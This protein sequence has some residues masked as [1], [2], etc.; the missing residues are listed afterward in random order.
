MSERQ[1]SLH[2]KEKE[3]KPS[4]HVNING[5]TLEQATNFIYSGNKITDKI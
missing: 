5:E 3:L 4:V 2:S 1:R